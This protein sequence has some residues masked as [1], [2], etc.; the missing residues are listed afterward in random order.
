M[1]KER[2][3]FMGIDRLAA[4]ADIND[5]YPRP[6]LRRDEWQSLDGTWTLDG[7]DITVPYPPQSGKSGW[8]GEVPDVLVYRR[9]FD[10]GAIPDGYRLILHF[11]AVDQCA[12]VCVNGIPAGSHEGGYLPFSFDITDLVRG[13]SN[14]LEVT[15]EDRLSH[16]YP[17]GKQTDSPGGM[18]YTPV[19]GIWQTVWLEK[20]PSDHITG[21]RFDADPF[22]GQVS[23]SIESTGDDAEIRVFCGGEEAASLRGLQGT[24]VIQDDMLRP[25][26]PEDPFLYT[27]VVTTPGGDQAGTYFAARKISL[28]MRG[29]VQRVCLNGEPV[30]LHGVLDQGYWPEGIFLPD[31]ISCYEK[32]IM[33]M[34][35]MGFNTLRKHIKL[36]PEAFYFACDRL[37][38][39]VIQDMVNSGDYSFM[40][41]TVLP[42]IGIRKLND[43]VREPGKRE[44]FFLTHMLKTAD[45]LYG[46]PCVVVYTIFNEGWGQ[47]N[48][49]QAYDMLKE[50][51]PSRL[52]D[53]AS[54]WFVPERS[55][56][57]SVHIYFRTVRLKPDIRPMLL[58]EC[59]GFIYETEPG[60][61]GRV[62]GYGRCES[63]QALTER[64]RSMYRKMVIPAV[65]DGLCGCI[66]T[67]L[68]DVE[69]EINGLVTYDRETVKA[70]PGGIR[71]IAGWIRKELKGE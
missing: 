11:G 62:W 57:D 37:G 50:R 21:V 63:S 2:R 43:T 22:T 20:V 38:M 45:R 25:W 69:S 14:E 31:D 32:D 12:R 53:T 52:I 49:S 10:P 28:E 17:Y 59:G 7:R 55:D 5:G 34:K 35:D 33:L 68:S 1:L 6:L 4:A 39:L 47:F 71:E 66:Y 23:W 15:A 54:G 9:E 27:A 16:D 18:W 13:G 58:S 48:S 26:S 65:K 70:D 30:F 56:F 61:N 51:D 8:E 29:G 41:D 19:S 44:E 60:K 24:F 67:Q 42:T 36:E 40:R 46:H 64:I 3:K